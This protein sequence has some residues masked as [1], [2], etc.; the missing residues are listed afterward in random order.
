MSFVLHHIGNI[1]AMYQQPKVIDK[2]QFLQDIARPWTSLPACCYCMLVRRRLSG[3]WPQSVNAYS[4]ITTTPRWLGHWST[5]VGLSSHGMINWVTV[6]V[7]VF[8]S[9]EVKAQSSFSDHNLSI[10]VVVV[11]SHSCWGH[12]SH[13]AMVWHLSTCAYIFSRAKLYQI[14]YVA[15]I[16]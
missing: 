2:L 4:Q 8:S 7:N 9:P 12:L 6:V 3:C 11:V 1:P 13:S 10:V 14:W 15:F 16:W 5:N